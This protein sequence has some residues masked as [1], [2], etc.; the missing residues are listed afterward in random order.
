MSEDNNKWQPAI[1][2]P[3]SS[4]CP[5]HRKLWDELAPDNEDLVLARRNTEGKKVLVRIAA[6]IVH[7]GT[8]TVRDIPA[9]MCVPLEI[10]NDEG[11]TAGCFSCEVM[12]D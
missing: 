6:A 4:M 11:R 8:T 2:L 5:A 9:G 3:L 10:M 7:I 12:T 1:L